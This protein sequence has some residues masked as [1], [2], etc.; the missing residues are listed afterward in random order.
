MDRH[1]SCD[2]RDYSRY[3]RTTLTDKFLDGL[4]AAVQHAPVIFEKFLSHACCLGVGYLAGA[5]V[6]CFVWGVGR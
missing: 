2:G 3:S 1:L 6:A 5:F 4:C